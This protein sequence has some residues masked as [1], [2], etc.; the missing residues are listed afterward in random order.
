MNIHFKTAFN[1]I[2]RAPFQ[3][4]AAVSV[5]GLTFFVATILAIFVYSSNKVL[6]YFE[7]RPQVIAFL[8]DEATPEAIDALQKKLN[9]DIRIKN[10]HY[11]SKEEAL[12]IY[13]SATAD[14]PLLGELVSPSIFPA[15]LEFSVS[16]LQYANEVIDEV[17]KEGVVDSVGFT[18]SLGSEEKLG[19]VLERLKSITFYIRIGGLVIF[20][21]LGITSF[22]VLL[23][24]ISLRIA[25][26]RSEIESLDLIGATTA[27]IRAP[28]V[29]EAISYAFLGVI[30]G[31]LLALILVLYS[32]P[33]IIAYFGEIPVLP[34]TPLFFFGLLL[35]I[36]FGEFLIGI[37]IALGGSLLAVSRARAKK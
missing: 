27:F 20:S 8:K 2:R 18:A 1:Y 23:V 6:T 15:S 22:L 28:I 16:D 33:A 17:K 11:V 21:V 13:K 14:N 5:L 19:D 31:W 24:V 34:K 37:L 4:L 10:L 29:L 7:T 12:E 32:T 25:T 26:R 3:A 30:V 35:V 9:A 36:L